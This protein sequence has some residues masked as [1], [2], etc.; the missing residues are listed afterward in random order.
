M[1][2]PNA[3]ARGLFHVDPR[4]AEDVMLTLLGAADALDAAARASG[5]RLDRARADAVN[6]LVE[7]LHDAEENRQTVVETEATIG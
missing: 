6:A 4:G 7:A 5:T 1:I 3:V 2:D